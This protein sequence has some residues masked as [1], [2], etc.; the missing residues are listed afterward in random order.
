MNRYTIKI[1]LPQW[2]E[3]KTA[4]IEAETKAKA[5]KKV[6]EFIKAECAKQEISFEPFKS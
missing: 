6:K 5:V 3:S 1:E 4:Y 2:N